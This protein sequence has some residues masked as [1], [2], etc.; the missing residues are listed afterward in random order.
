[1]TAVRKYEWTW[2]GMCGQ[3]ERSEEGKA[4]IHP[5]QKPVGLLAEII[6]D[7]SEEGQTVLDPFGGSGS[8]LI[9]CEKT[10]R[11]CFM[12]EYEPAY[13]DLIV[14]RWQ[15]YTGKEAVRSDGVKYND[16]RKDG[17]NACS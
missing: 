9:A 16:L 2:N 11:K 6:A 5:T 15:E 13:I 8:T 10:G 7:Y 3:G 1:M 4:R 12:I 17:D 14:K